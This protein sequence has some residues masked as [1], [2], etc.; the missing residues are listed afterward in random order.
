ME[1]DEIGGQVSG[2]H[3]GEGHTSGGHPSEGHTS[4]SGGQ[5]LKSQANHK[6]AVELPYRVTEKYYVIIHNQMY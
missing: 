4:G 6:D 1:R 5:F 3:S 2:G